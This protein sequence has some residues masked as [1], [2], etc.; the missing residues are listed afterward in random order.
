M[1]E[2]VQAEEERE[3]IVATLEINNQ[4]LCFIYIR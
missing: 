1:E 2:E 4:L 3:V